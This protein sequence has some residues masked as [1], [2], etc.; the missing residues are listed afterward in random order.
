MG[1]LLKGDREV[2]QELYVVENLRKQLL[3]RPAVEVLELAVC[4]EAVEGERRS[5]IDQFPKLFQG[6]GKLES[7]RS[8]SK[9]EQNPLL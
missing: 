7:T 1:K 4:I 6:L 5:P 2:E 8:N 9:R 3:G